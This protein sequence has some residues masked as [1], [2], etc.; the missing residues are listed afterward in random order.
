M[1]P[2]SISACPPLTEVD[3][4]DESQFIPQPLPPLPPLPSESNVPHNEGRDKPQ[5]PYDQRPVVQPKP[6]D[7]S[8]PWKN[9]GLMRDIGGVEGFKKVQNGTHRYPEDR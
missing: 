7:P 3:E 4:V 6:F 9:A 2:M 1:E 5:V 8:N